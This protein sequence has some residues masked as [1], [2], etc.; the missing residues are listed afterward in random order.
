MHLTTIGDHDPQAMKDGKYDFVFE[1]GDHINDYT[2]DK[3]PVPPPEEDQ[4]F[5]KFDGNEDSTRGSSISEK[6]ET[7]VVSED[8]KDSKDSRE[9]KETLPKNYETSRRSYPSQRKKL[10]M[11]RMPWAPNHNLV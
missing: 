7:D 8:S 1:D 11:Q 2:L 3:I 10:A 9:S 4:D 6:E 5:D